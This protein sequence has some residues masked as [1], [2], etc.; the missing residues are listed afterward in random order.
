MG[1]PIALCLTAGQTS[2]HLGAK[3][4][5][6]VLPDGPD[7]TLIG[8]KGYDSD[9]YRA[10]LRAK[11]ITACIPPRKGRNSPASFCKIQ[12]KQR[13]KIENMFGRLKDWRKVAIRYDRCAH[14]FFLG[15][16][17]RSYRNIMRPEPSLLFSIRSSGPFK[18]LGAVHTLWILSMVC[19]D[20]G[21]HNWR[22]HAQAAGARHK[23]GGLCRTW[24]DR[25]RL[26]RVTI[27]LGTLGG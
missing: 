19:S 13:H 5:Y 2:D 24:S 16:T 14:T 17:H 18:A 15:H 22:A 10:A 7:I 1:R 27:C 6:P 23:K 20:D 21:C 8:D 25:C 11:G 26:Q 3:I 9:D 4:L 12:Y